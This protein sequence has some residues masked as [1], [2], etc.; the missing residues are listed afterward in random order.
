MGTTWVTHILRALFTA[1]SPL[2]TLNPK[3]DDPRLSDTRCELTS[4]ESLLT[5]QRSFSDTS[6]IP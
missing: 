6:G 3:A 4:R 2:P 5:I 1:A